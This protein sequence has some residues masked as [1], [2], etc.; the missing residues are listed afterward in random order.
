MQNRHAHAKPHKNTRTKPT[1]SLIRDVLAEK[2][3]PCP[4][5]DLHDG[6]ASFFDAAM[7]PVVGAGKAS[8]YAFDPFASCVASGGVVLVFLEGGCSLGSAL[9]RRLGCALRAR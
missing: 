3:V 8:S 1:R 6:F 9:R 5:V 4:A 2:S 7:K